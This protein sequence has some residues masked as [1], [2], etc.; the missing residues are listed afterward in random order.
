MVLCATEISALTFHPQEL[1]TVSCS[2]TDFKVWVP[3]GSRRNSG[4]SWR[5]R[6]IGSYRQKLILAAAFSS[7]GTILAVAASELLTLWNP[8]TNTLIRVLANPTLSF[9]P[10]SL[11]SFVN[12]STCLVAASSGDQPRVTLWDLST[13]SVCW[14]HSLSVEAIAVDPTRPN[15]AVLAGLPSVLK[16]EGGPQICLFYVPVRVCNGENLRKVGNGHCCMWKG[17]MFCSP[18]KFVKILL[19]HNG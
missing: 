1:M 5:C 7:D 17:E 10:I 19:V 3:N 12:H 4:F 15:F 2:H 9:E 8:V 18:L 16:D 13:L 14:S 6:S 11:L